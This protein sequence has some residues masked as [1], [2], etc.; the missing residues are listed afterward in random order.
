[1][2]QLSLE[3]ARRLIDEA[4]DQGRMLNLKPLAVVVLDAG[5]HMI[6]CQRQDGASSGRVAVAAGKAGGALFLGVS[7]R[8]LAEMAA[9]RP[10]FL[11]SLGPIASAG[12]VPAAGG[13]L[14]Y[15]EEDHLVGAVGISG[16]TSDNDEACALAAAKAVGFA[17]D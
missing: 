1:M 13:I 14:L 12:M 17:V 15:D 4:L 11:A 3:H 10:S 5:G 9:E 2:T 6:A 7:S 8:K 16:D